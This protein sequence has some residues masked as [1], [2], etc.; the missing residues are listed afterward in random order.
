[1]QK[2]KISYIKTCDHG[3]IIK[4]TIKKSTAYFLIFNNKN[5]IKNVYTHKNLKKSI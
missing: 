3:K 4:H 2:E 1:M 5:N